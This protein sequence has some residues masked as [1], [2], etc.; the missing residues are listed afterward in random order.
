MTIL[1]VILVLILTFSISKNTFS[2]NVVIIF[3]IENEII[4]IYDI[5][6]EI[7]YLTAF[8]NKLKN[9]PKKKNYSYCDQLDNT[10]EN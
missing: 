1:R 9:L 2:E 10:R 7:N 6:Q 3:K 8:N 5:K 4:T